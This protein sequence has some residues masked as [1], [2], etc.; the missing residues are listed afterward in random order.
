MSPDAPVDPV[1]AFASTVERF[2]ALCD[3]DPRPENERLWSLR[4]ALGELIAGT[5]RL[6]ASWGTYGGGADEPSYEHVVARIGPRYPSL[7]FYHD[8][9]NSLDVTA[10]RDRSIGDAID[11]LADIYSELLSGLGHLRAGRRREAV[12]DWLEGFRVHWGRH[13]VGAL[14][15]VHDC[16]TESAWRPP[17]AG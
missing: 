4:G 9:L 14:R 11:D 15:A 12:A 13:A 10:D 17:E 16:L 3:D 7:G 8:V 6:P 1:T 5:D 2:L